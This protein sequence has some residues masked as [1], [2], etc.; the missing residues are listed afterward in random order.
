MEPFPERFPDILACGHFGAS[1]RTE[2]YVCRERVCVGLVGVGGKSGDV[3][4]ALLHHQGAV[5][6][7]LSVD[8]SQ[9][10]LRV[11]TFH[12]QRVALL[13]DAEYGVVGGGKRREIRDEPV[14]SEV[15]YHIVGSYAAVGEHCLK[16]G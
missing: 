8:V 7:D 16:V 4:T 12:P 6:C 15:D 2:D 5:A 13:G 3:R 9:R 10:N 1:V 14:F 11:G